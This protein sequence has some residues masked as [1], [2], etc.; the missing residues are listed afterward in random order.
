M[1]TREEGLLFIGE[2]PTDISLKSKLIK[3]KNKINTPHDSDKS[4]L[5]GILIFKIIKALKKKKPYLCFS[6]SSQKLG[7]QLIKNKLYPHKGYIL[8]I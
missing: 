1:L 4:Y 3:L 2:V 5:K 8:F 6:F 7:L